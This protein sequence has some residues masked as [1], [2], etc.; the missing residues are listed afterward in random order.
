M[1]TKRCDNRGCWTNHRSQHAAFAKLTLLPGLW[2][3]NTGRC[4]RRA[5]TGRTVFVGEAL[6]PI[7][8]RL[9][10]I[11]SVACWV[12]LLWC[13]FPQTSIAQRSTP[14]VISL[15]PAQS[16]VENPLKG[17]VPY[18][19]P[20][21]ERFPHSMEFAY[22]HLSQLVIGAEQYDFQ[23]LE[24]RLDDIASRGNQTIFRVV[25]EY[26]GRSGVIPDYLL[27]QGL[28][29]HRYRQSDS[30]PA[31]WVETPDYNNPA[32][33]ECLLRFIQTLGDRYDGDPRIAYITAGLLGIWGEWHN[34][35]REDLWASKKLQAKVLE[36][37]QRSFTRT[38]ILLRYPAGAD[39][40]QYAPNNRLRFGYHDDSFAFATAFSQKEGTS[41]YFMNRMKKAEALD[42]W[43][44]YPIGGEIR[45]EVWGCCF[46]PEPCTPPEQ[47]FATCRQQTHV[48]WLMDSGLFTKVPSPQRLARAEDQVRKMGYDF[49][50]ST[51]EV[52]NKEDSV[53]QIDLT[54]RNQGIAPFYHSGWQIHLG[55]YSPRERR[56]VRQWKTPWTLNDIQ[57]DAEMVTRWST[58]LN[59]AQIPDEWVLTIRVPNPMP[60]GKTLYF[61]NRY[62]DGQDG[63]PLA[64][65]KQLIAQ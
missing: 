11:P 3:N 9:L 8:F 1:P 47:D 37:Y 17:L 24:K 31:S 28:R 43:R 41:W 20:P 25:L 19:H 7:V 21:A 29:V 18:A 38:P 42:K 22:L 14:L 23:P 62:P 54:V 52:R 27:G 30:D 12:S 10:R 59:L 63:L 2:Y 55:Y 61:A 34:H 40:R 57:P 5:V 15:P 49:R 33:Q 32:L 53:Y 39:D 46:D 65:V 16:P 13:L 64:T 45:P 58:N 36:T 51:L 35:P 48:T 26:P 56:L 50:L 6:L 4:H 44:D 60:G